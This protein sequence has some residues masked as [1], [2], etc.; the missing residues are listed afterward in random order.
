MN[1][2]DFWV[3]LGELVEQ[4]QK[5]GVTVDAIVTMLQDE[6][7]ELTPEDEDDGDDKEDG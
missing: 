4:A 5:D 7:D 1:K 3:K 6:M 2:G